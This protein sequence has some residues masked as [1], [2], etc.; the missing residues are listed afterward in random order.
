[1]KISVQIIRGG[2]EVFAG[3]TDLGQI[4][5]GFDELA[6]FLF[7]ENEFPLGAYLMTG[8]GVVPGNDF[9]LVSGDVVNISIDG[10]GTL[11][12]EVE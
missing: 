10:I 12:N 6:E 1:M 4:K 3:D 7:R 11:S 8:T 9:S 5:R 2:D